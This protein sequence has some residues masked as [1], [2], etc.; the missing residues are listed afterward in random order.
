MWCQQ[1]N[2]PGA[3]GR[4]QRDFLKGYELKPNYVKNTT[5]VSSCDLEQV[6]P[7]K[8]SNQKYVQDK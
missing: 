6:T 7:T 2:K 4:I 8:Y 5:S 1:Y 3:I